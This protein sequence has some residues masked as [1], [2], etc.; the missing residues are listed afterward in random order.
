MCLTYNEHS[1][2]FSCYD[3]N[4]TY[5]T[6]AFVMILANILRYRTLSLSLSLS[7]GGDLSAQSK[8]RAVLATWTLPD[9]V[10]TLLMDTQVQWLFNWL[11]N[12]FCLELLK[13]AQTQ[14][15]NSK[16]GIF[17]SQAVRC[18][19]SFLGEEYHGFYGCIK[20]KIWKSS[21]TTL[22]NL[23]PRPVSYTS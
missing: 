14:M 13:D 11:L 4:I 6:T 15:S 8:G 19:P 1:V 2:H 9:L 20:Q 5:E 12:I 3:I 10:R 17:L 7:S 16:L 23:S 18:Q 22:W 21:L